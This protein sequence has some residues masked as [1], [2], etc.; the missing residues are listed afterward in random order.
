ME[1]ELNGHSYL[2]AMRLDVAA[3]LTVV[4]NT[5]GGVLGDRN[6]CFCANQKAIVSKRRSYT[7]DRAA[8]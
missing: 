6:P 7:T 5:Q 3:K 1:L 8:G 2:T 4:A